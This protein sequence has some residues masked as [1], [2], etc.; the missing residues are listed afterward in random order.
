[1][2]IED[3]VFEVEIHQIHVPNFIHEAGSSSLEIHPASD[4]GRWQEAG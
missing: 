4:K 1:M 3:I 2:A